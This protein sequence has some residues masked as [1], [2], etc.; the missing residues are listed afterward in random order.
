MLKPGI[1]GPNRTPHTPTAW[2]LPLIGTRQCWIYLPLGSQLEYCTQ[3]KPTTL[4]RTLLTAG[5]NHDTSPD[6]GKPTQLGNPDSTSPEFHL[7][8]FPLPPGGIRHRAQRLKPLVTL[9]VEGS[10]WPSIKKG[11]NAEGNT[12]ALC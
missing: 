5:S 4:R 12:K 6:R 11:L 3:S 10:W 2:F 1:S 9:F 8:P 7:R